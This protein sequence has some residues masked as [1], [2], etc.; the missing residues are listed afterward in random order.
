MFRLFFSLSF[1][2]G[3]A[4]A[5]TI[6]TTATCDG[7]TTTGITDANCDSDGSTANAT[8][9]ITTLPFGAGV[10][11]TSS[12]PGSASAS[13]NFSG[14]YVFTV[15][16]GNGGGLFYPC[17][18]ANSFGSGVGHGAFDGTSFTFAT[19]QSS[20]C[21]VGT[22]LLVL[23][24]AFTFGVPQ[25]VLFGVG[26]TAATSVSD[27]ESGADVSLIG[28]FLADTSGNLLP[29]A[30]FTLVEIPES[31]SWSSLGIGLAFFLAVPICRVRFR[32]GFHRR[33]LR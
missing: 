1:A 9:G 12:P 3:V 20:S 29:N 13:A 15:F 30:T 31:S 25:I 19:A 11:V 10:L 2:L 28:F 22:V 16:G 26:A 4:T 24:N 6:I 32:G 27:F 17:F 18:R 14:D 33:D 5:A 21:G 23:S 8:L 7:V